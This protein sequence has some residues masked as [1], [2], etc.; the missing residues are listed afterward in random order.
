[1]GVNLNFMNKSEGTIAAF[2]EGQGDHWTAV[3]IVGLAGW[4][5]QHGAYIMLH[6]SHPGSSAPFSAPPLAAVVRAAG[7]AVGTTVAA[8][9][10]PPGE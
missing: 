2:G 8:A 9:G 3:R 5:K 7:L 6:P 4:R 10:T 1:M